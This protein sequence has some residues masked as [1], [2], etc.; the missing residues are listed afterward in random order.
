[1]TKL[2][3][4]W[5]DLEDNNELDIFIKSEYIGSMESDSLSR[6]DPMDHK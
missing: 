3:K 1:M 4:K 6:F 2:N 5:I